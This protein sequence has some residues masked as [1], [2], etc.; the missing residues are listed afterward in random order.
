[1]ENVKEEEILREEKA[2]ENSLYGIELVGF[3]KALKTTLTQPPPPPPGPV[4]INLPSEVARFA[5]FH[6]A[7]WDPPPT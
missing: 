4:C 1:M 5:G 3:L 2:K 7:P 6:L